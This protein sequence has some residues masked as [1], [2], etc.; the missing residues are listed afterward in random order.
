[1]SLEKLIGLVMPPQRPLQLPNKSMWEELELKSGLIFPSEYKN[2]ISLYG[3][4]EFSQYLY[5]I[6]PFW[7]FWEGLKRK[8]LTYNEWIQRKLKDYLFLKEGFSVE[9][10]FSIYPEKAGLYP[11]ATTVEGEVLYWEVEGEPNTWSTILYSNG[12]EHERWQISTTDFLYKWLTGNLATTILP[13][14]NL[15]QSFTPV[16]V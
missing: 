15:V 8:K 11:W 13:T 4:G 12:W 6:N 7:N 3:S 9:Y 1:M 5:V 2:C 10:P 14:Q 16:F